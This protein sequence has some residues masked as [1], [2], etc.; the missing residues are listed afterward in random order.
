MEGGL[1]LRATWEW[2]EG[3]RVSANSVGNR[4]VATSSPAT[5]FKEF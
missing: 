2:A 3:P 4:Q 1:K 5:T